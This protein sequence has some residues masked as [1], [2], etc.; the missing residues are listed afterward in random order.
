M[1]CQKKNSKEEA[2]E[3][4]LKRTLG[5]DFSVVQ[6][7]RLHTS[8]TGDAG[9]IPGWGTKIPHAAHHWGKKKTYF[10]SKFQALQ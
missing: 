10:L 3:R 8:N 1:F 7:L 9:S 2:L 6:W 5:L 4:G